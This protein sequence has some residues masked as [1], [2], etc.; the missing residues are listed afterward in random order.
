VKTDLN[1]SEDSVREIKQAID[2]LDISI[3]VN[4]A[5]VSIPCLIEVM[6]WSHI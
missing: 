3:F 4:N 6:Q 5:G 1:K 2:G